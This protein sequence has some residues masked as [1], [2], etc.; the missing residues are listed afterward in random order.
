MTPL[1]TRWALFIGGL[2]A[3][4][5][6]W[7]LAQRLKWIAETQSRKGTIEVLPTGV[8]LWRSFCGYASLF[9]RLVSVV[10]ALT[11]VALLFMK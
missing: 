2:G 5:L 8:L 1:Q 3:A 6:S 7:L 10:A 9:L 4:I 11:S